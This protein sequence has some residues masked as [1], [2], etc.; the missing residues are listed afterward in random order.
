MYHLSNIKSGFSGATLI[1]LFNGQPTPQRREELERLFKNKF[2]G[3]QGQ[4]IVFMYHNDREE[5][6]EVKN[7]PIP[8]A[9]EL[10]KKQA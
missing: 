8:E 4:K 3:S 5:M 6:A 7:A 9:K 10:D 1:Q 2:S